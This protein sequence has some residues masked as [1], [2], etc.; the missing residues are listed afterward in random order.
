MVG[1]RL[2][3]VLSGRAAGCARLST[4]PSQAQPG[5][6]V[7]FRWLEAGLSQSPVSTRKGP[8]LHPGLHKLDVNAD[9][10][11]FDNAKYANEMR[12]KEGRFD[13]H[14]SEVLETSEPQAERE[15]WRLVSNYLCSKYP[16]NFAVTEAGEG[17]EP[18]VVSVTVGKH[19]RSVSPRSYGYLE[20]AARLA[21]EDLFVLT[22]TN[23][24]RLASA[25]CC[26]SFAGA[27]ERARSRQSL[28]QL[29][30]RVGGY[31]KDLSSSVT[32]YFKNLTAP[33]WRSNW[34]ISLSDN[35]IPSADRDFLNPQKRAETFDAPPEDP[36][37][38]LTKLA[39]DGVER[40]CFC[41]VEYQTIR[42]LET[43]NAVLFTVHTYVVP[44]ANLSPQA[45]RNLAANVANA[46]EH[47]VRIYK[48]LQDRR[49]ADFILTYLNNK[50]SQAA[51]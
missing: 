40:S 11:V 8:R 37:H 2:S 27:G 33:V 25:A 19:H 46:C 4:S 13:G 51:S 34:S 50:G 10:L 9:W 22:T 38:V 29:H 35:L 23:G 14:S 7:G 6:L 30:A 36:E 18:I 17:G 41:K 21:Q 47:D 49:I 39:K 24:V 43:P 5:S 45:A 32:R 3:R 16:S 20:A 48:N 26:F 12:L 1:G 15:T 44:F 42:N 28:D 31:E